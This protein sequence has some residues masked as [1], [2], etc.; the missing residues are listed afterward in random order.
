MNEII[1]LLINFKI[2]QTDN[3]D[4]LLEKFESASLLNPQ[5]EWVNLQNYYSKLKFLKE[6]LDRTTNIPEFKKFID[7]ISKQ[8]VYYMQ[9][10]DLDPNNYTTKEHYFTR[11]TYEEV[12]SFMNIINKCFEYSLNTNDPYSVLDHTVLAYSYLVKLAEDARGDYYKYSVDQEFVDTFKRR[13]V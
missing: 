10:I 11:Y 9:N 4:S 8:N 3:F 12:I 2:T 1:D 6:S 13:K 7:V 5:Q